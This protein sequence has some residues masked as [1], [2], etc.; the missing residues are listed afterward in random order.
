MGLEQPCIFLWSH[1]MDTRDN[2][3]ENY[4]HVHTRTHVLTNVCKD[5]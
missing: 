4:T 3:A 5:W 1:E 2:T